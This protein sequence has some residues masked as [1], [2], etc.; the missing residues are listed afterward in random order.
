[1]LSLRF[2]LAWVGLGL[3]VA[4]VQACA[5]V[6]SGIPDATGGGGSGTA[7]ASGSSGGPAPASCTSADCE[8]IPTGWTLVRARVVDPAVDVSA[9]PNCARG[10]APTVYFHGPVEPACGPCTCGQPENASCSAPQITCSYS[11]HDCSTNDVQ[12]QDSTDSCSTHVPGVLFGNSNGSCKITGPGKVT[13]PGTCQAQGGGV[14]PASPFEGSVVLCPEPAMADGCDNGRSCLPKGDT[15]DGAVCITRPDATPCP[16]GWTAQDLPAFEGANDMRAC[17]A[18]ACEVACTGGSYV[19]YTQDFCISDTQATV[20]STI[21]TQAGGI[22][23][24]S[25]ASF[26]STQATPVL[27]ACN[28]PAASGIVAGIGVHQVCCR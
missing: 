23:D 16:A 12:L 25:T 5:L 20:D 24:W 15:A 13:S 7:G 4:S 11:T 6:T 3:L 22:F 19:V 27:G 1:V 17:A 28:P 26:Q 10:G 9:L 14:T 2:P 18:C 8:T 21:C